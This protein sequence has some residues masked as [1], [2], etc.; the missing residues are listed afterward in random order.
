MFLCLHNTN[1]TNPPLQ[2]QISKNKHVIHKTAIHFLSLNISEFIYENMTK[3]CAHCNFPESNLKSWNYY[4][5]EIVTVRK[6]KPEYV[7]ICVWKKGL[8]QL[9]IIISLFNIIEIT[10]NSWLTVPTLVFFSQLHCFRGKHQCCL[11]HVSVIH[12]GFRQLVMQQKW[13]ENIILGFRKST[14]YSR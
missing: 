4:H 6:L 5:K 1:S 11:P 12:L 14:D 7:V 8:K 2:N 3:N 13:Y 10:G 9:I